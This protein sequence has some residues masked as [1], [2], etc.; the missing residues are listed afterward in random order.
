LIFGLQFLLWM[1]YRYAAA[2]LAAAAR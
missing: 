1:E 2:G